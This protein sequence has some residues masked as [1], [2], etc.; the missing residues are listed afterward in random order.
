MTHP[1][2]EYLRNYR[3]RKDG[4]PDY[5]EEDMT[6]CLVCQGKFVFLGAHVYQTHKIY[7][8]DY[9]KQFGLDIKK[10]RTRGQFKKLKADTNKGVANLEKGKQYRFK[11]GHKIGVYERSKETM[12][13]LQLKS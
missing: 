4:K 13:R 7:M 1:R 9:K 8:H 10:G 2:N 12:N 6:E 11:K 3:A 5:T